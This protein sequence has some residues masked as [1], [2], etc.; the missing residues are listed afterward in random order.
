V[1]GEV[2]IEPCPGGVLLRLGNASP[3][4]LTPADEDALRTALNI[5]E[6]R[7]VAVTRRPA[8]P[9]VGGVLSNSARHT[10][11]AGS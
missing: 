7:R 9:S 6:G 11:P 10:S 3:V 4:R 8:Q 2:R 1:S 5:R